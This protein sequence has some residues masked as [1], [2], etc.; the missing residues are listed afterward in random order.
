MTLGRIESYS[1]FGST[2]DS[3]DDP[4]IGPLITEKQTKTMRKRTYRLVCRLLGEEQ[5][6]FVRGCQD[7]S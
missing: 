4:T 6:L 5:T 7:R 2:P 3:T 1:D